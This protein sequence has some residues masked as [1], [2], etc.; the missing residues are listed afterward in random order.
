VTGRGPGRGRGYAYG[1]E[2]DLEHW[3]RKTLTD[4]DEKLPGRLLYYHT[5]RSDKSPAGFPDW[6]FTGPGGV[7]FR[8]LKGAK[9]QLKP[10]QQAW[11]EMLHRARAD[12]DVWRPADRMSGRISAELR[13]VAGLGISERDRRSD[14]ARN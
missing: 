13:A 4:Y 5:H 12:V 9:E 1:G 6:V 14:D 10:A 8:E 3:L 11:Y 7:I 2:G